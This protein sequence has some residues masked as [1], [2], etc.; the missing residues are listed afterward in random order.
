MWYFFTLWNWVIKKWPKFIVERFYFL[1]P[2]FN[3]QVIIEQCCYCFSIMPMSRLFFV[4][5]HWNIYVDND[6]SLRVCIERWTMCKL[7]SKPSKQKWRRNEKKLL[8]MC[9]K[10]FSHSFNNQSHNFKR[11]EI[12]I[13][14]LY[15]FFISKH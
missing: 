15:F 10:Q 4:P 13:F 6:A 5:S 3:L 1:C 7:L 9:K 8:Q 2:V 14:M 12:S 11:N